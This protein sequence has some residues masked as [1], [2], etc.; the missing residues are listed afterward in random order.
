MQRPTAKHQA[1]L[2]GVLC[3]RRGNRIKLARGVKDTTR[4]TRSTNLGPWGLTEPGPPT[5]EHAGARLR[6]PS[7]LW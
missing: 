5:K 1:K 4:H 6:A 3:G 2:K 7:H